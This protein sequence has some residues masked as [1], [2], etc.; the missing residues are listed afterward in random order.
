MK[1]FMDTHS[2]FVHNVKIILQFF[3]LLSASRSVL[4]YLCDA[5]E[6]EASDDVAGQNAIK[7]DFPLVSA[8]K[9]GAENQ[10]IG[11]HVFAMPFRGIRSRIPSIPVS[12]RHLAGGT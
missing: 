5:G 4:P 1:L 12:A 7:V 8:D 2:I 11:S 10:F 3:W 9:G 6:T